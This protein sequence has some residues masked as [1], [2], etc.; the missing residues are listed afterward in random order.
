M[1]TGLRMNE[2]AREKGSSYRRQWDRKNPDRQAAIMARYWLKKAASF[3]YDYE[4]LMGE[5]VKRG[6]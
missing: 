6:L 1:E 3:G 5:G 2:P 4:T